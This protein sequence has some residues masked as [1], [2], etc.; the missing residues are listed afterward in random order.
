VRAVAGDRRRR[1]GGGDRRRCGVY[2]DGFTPDLTDAIN[3]IPY[4]GPAS[5][6]IRTVIVVIKVKSAIEGK[7]PFMLRV[8]RQFSKFLSDN[9]DDIARG[10]V[11]GPSGIAGEGHL[12]IEDFGPVGIAVYPMWY[13]DP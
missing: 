11:E 7:E 3:V 2:M 6:L 1:R 4:L 5:K 9:I 13:R 10:N 12:K 8:K